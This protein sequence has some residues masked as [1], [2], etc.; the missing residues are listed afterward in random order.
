MKKKHLFRALLALFLVAVLAVGG[1]VLDFH[2]NGGRLPLSHESV[3]KVQVHI[4]PPYLHLSDYPEMAQEDRLLFLD[5]SDPEDQKIIREALSL[6]EEFR[7]AKIGTKEDGAR[8]SDVWCI[9]EITYRHHRER[10]WFFLDRVRC[11][12]YLKE[13]TDSP[14]YLGKNPEKF[15]EKIERFA[16]IVY[17]EKNN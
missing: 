6:L 8:F 3:R 4:I 16:E 10:F 1:W 2:L 9:M 17:G 7:Y 13:S 15:R 14:T 11:F 12:N 5:N